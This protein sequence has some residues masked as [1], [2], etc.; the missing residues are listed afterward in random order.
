MMARIRT[1]WRA[2]R[3]RGE[4]ERGM[5]EELAAHVELR[6]AELERR[7]LPP[8]GALRQAR[9]EL[10]SAESQKEECRR[11]MGLRI[12]DEFLQDV[13]YAVRVLRRSP[14]FTAVA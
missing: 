10:G 4:W 11:S 13:R 12:G 9:L 7:G 5:A 1:L 14:G 3:R 6:A 8:A 2:A